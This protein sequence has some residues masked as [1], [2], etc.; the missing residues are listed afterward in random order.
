MLTGTCC[1][2]GWSSGPGDGGK[3]YRN[4]GNAAIAQSGNDRYGGDGLGLCAQHFEIV[5]HG[6]FV[7]P[8]RIRLPR[9]RVL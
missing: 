1:A 8:M 4:L 2:W 5:T 9:G 6:R 3:V 7:D